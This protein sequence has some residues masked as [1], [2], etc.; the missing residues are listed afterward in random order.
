VKSHRSDGWTG[1]GA[2]GGGGFWRYKVPN[3]FYRIGLLAVGGELTDNRNT[4]EG[5][6]CVHSRGA[7]GLNVRT[8][9]GSK[10]GTFLVTTIRLWTTAVAAIIASSIR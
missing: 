4:A 9:N 10:S 5:A 6:G 2:R 3:E 8:P 1:V 7:K